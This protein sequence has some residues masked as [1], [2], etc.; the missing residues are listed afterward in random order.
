MD[1]KRSSVRQRICSTNNDG[2]S[3]TLGNQIE[4]FPESELRVLEMENDVLYRNLTKEVDEVHQVA[5]KISEIGRLN[6]TLT[7]NL[8]EQLE[9]GHIILF[10]T[11]LNNNFY[12]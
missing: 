11:Y 10:D 2:L 4:S 12:Q 9:V 7:E 1:T 8:A 3:S 5:Q 6:Q